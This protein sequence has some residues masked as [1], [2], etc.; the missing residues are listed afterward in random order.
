MKIRVVPAEPEI[1]YSEEYY[2]SL[3]RSMGE[4]RAAWAR[5]RGFPSRKGSKPRGLLH[6]LPNFPLHVWRYFRRPGAELRVASFTV[7]FDIVD[8]QF[9][10]G[11][12]A[13]LRLD[14]FIR[15]LAN[16]RHV[17][18]ER[19]PSLKRDPFWFPYTDK[20]NEQL[21]KALKTMFGES[22]GGKLIRALLR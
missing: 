9:H 21:H 10:L 16:A 4:E 14:N 11:D 15:E 2:E 22:I 3:A 13:Y 19:V 6:A 8:Q 20:Q 17:N 18:Y 5:L 7:D 12:L 1:E